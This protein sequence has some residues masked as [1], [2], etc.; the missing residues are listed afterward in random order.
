MSERLPDQNGDDGSAETFPVR[1]AS[2]V[3][4]RPLPPLDDLSG[5]GSQ[6]SPAPDASR[7]HSP[8]SDE[9]SSHLTLL[10]RDGLDQPIE[11]LELCI[12]WPSGQQS[13]VMTR[14]LGAASVPLPDGPRLGAAGIAVRDIQ[15]QRQQVCQLDLEKCA[16]V[17]VIRSPKVAVRTS[18]RQNQTVRTSGKVATPARPGTSSST[19]AP[20][21]TVSPAP[22]S[23]PAPIG[24][25]AAHGRSA[26]GPL[27]L[28][29][30]KTAL[31][32]AWAWLQHDLQAKPG[33][34][35]AP[36]AP[37][38][39]LQARNAAGLPVSIVAGPECPNPQNLRLGRNNVYRD[40][41][42]QASKRLG[43]APQALCALIDCEAGKVVE[44]IPV[45][46]SQGKP[47]IDKR[48]KPLVRTIRELWNASAYNASS[49][50]AGMTQ[51][52]RSTWLAHVLIPGRFI[53]EESCKAGWV[54][55]EPLIK[56]GKPSGTRWVFVLSDGRTT[57]KPAAFLKDDHVKA[58]LDRRFDPLWSIMAAAEYGKANLEILRRAG[59]KLDGLTDMDKA[60]LMYLMHHEGEGAGPKFIENRLSEMRGG[61]ER[62]RSTFRLQVGTKRADELVQQSADDVELAYRRWL[63]R[64]IDDQFEHADS[65]FCSNTGENRQIAQIFQI[66]KQ[67]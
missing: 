7:A 47:V 43:L 54:R 12:T 65:Y 16:S 39:L 46:D 15:G 37:K 23:Q 51:F 50:A 21:T 6:G 64:F 26:S 41:I 22:L 49:H 29:W 34:A 27:P 53:H 14:A 18:L 20:K 67:K 55:Q 36:P 10:L 25:P 32:R 24:T 42:L 60:K 13:L 58:C 56:S 5:D 45:L 17:A 28:E 57:P 33:A 52:L 63:M 19:A 61:V 66:I 44:R 2:D 35:S 30:I 62:L 59:Y 40:A 38:A 11:G 1:P 9:P 3:E 8:E 4:L 48:G 31:D